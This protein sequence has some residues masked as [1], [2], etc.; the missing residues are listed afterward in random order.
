MLGTPFRDRARAAKA[1][2]LVRSCFL[3]E[4]PVKLPTRIT[5]NSESNTT[6]CT[7]HRVRRL[8]AAAVKKDY[9]VSVATTNY[10]FP[11]DSP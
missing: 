9:A 8:L 10:A 6:K 2:A 11:S 7:Q 4:Q 5:T 3:S 1:T